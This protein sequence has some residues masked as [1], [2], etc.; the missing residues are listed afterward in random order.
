MITRVVVESG[1]TSIGENAFAYCSRL[2]KVVFAGTAPSIGKNAFHSVRA[3]VYD[4]DGDAKWT[5]GVRQ[6]Y[7]GTQNWK[8]R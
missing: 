1:V 2:S 6:N 3:M 5:T 8:K 4:P 7:G